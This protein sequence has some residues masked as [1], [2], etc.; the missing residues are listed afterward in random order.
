M[1]WEQRRWAGLLTIA[2]F[3]T[4]ACMGAATDRPVVPAQDPAATSPSSLPGPSVDDDRPVAP[5][6]TLALG[7]GGSYTLSADTKPVYLVFWAEW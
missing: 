5:D 4:A 2:A 1:K 7:E 3:I 6:F